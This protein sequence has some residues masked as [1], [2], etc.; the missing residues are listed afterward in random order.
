MTYAWFLSRLARCFGII[1]CELH[2]FPMKRFALAFGLLATLVPFLLKADGVVVFNEVMY[3]PATNEPA[4]E[5]L[6]FYNQNAVDVDLSGWRVANGIDYTF[7]NG[8][9]IRGGSYLVLAISPTALNAQT[10]L[11]NILGPFSGRLSNSGETLELRDNNNRLMDS[12]KYGVDG[13]WPVG[14]DGGGPSLVKINPN[15]SSKPAANW[16]ASSQIGGSPGAINFSTVLR[17]GAKTNL[18]NTTNSWRF[19]DSGTDLGGALADT[20]V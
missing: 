18:V 3:H 16:T 13:D 11:T 17:T 12:V 1:V 4:L 9:I 6:E 19:N 14:T 7:P 8:T 15:L 10:G 20:C 5:W 2:P